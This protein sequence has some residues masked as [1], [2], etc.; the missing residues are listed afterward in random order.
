MSLFIVTP[1]FHGGNY[2]KY[3]PILAMT[4]IRQLHISQRTF[5]V[6]SH[7]SA[8]R[9][10]VFLT[11]RVF[12]QNPPIRANE[13]KS[14]RILPCCLQATKTVESC[15]LQ[16]TTFLLLCGLQTLTYWRYRDKCHSGL[17]RYGDMQYWYK[18]D[19]MRQYARTATEK[20]IMADIDRSNRD[21]ND[22]DYLCSHVVLLPSSFFTK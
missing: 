1:N 13:H 15:G 14:E 21:C 11:Q 17:W 10:K 8:R 12:Y 16:T 6:G 7:I 9:I 3:M 20:T 4:L 2:S 22:D 5:H 18:E 19:N